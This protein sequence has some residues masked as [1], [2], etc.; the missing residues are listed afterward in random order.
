MNAQHALTGPPKRLDRDAHIIF[1]SISTGNIQ[2]SQDEQDSTSNLGISSSGPYQRYI[3]QTPEISHG[4][5]PLAIVGHGVVHPVTRRGISA[6]A[7][8]LRSG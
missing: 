4:H 7:G 3:P 6:K 2:N 1:S 8:A 5:L